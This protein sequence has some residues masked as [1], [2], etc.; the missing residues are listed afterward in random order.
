MNEDGEKK[1]GCP[2]KHGM[3]KTMESEKIGG[4]DRK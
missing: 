2:P 4:I 3:G 1:C